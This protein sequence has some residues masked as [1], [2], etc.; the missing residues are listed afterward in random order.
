MLKAYRHR[1][2]RG[3][4]KNLGGKESQELGHLVIEFSII[5][6]LVLWSYRASVAYQ[7]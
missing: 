5:A 6:I 4:S 3:F 7:R 2:R 1:K